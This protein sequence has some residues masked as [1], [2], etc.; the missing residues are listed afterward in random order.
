MELNFDL[1]PSQQNTSRI[2][3]RTDDE[4]SSTTRTVLPTSIGLRWP[5]AGP[6]SSN[7]A[8]SAALVDFAFSP[9][10]FRGLKRHSQLEPKICGLDTG[11]GAHLSQM[12]S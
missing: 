9:T 12:V 4:Y 5:A 6:R 7:A 8:C 10:K 11:Y 2:L 1:N 3:G